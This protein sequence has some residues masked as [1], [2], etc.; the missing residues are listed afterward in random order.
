MAILMYG[1][2]PIPREVR[3]N[4]RMAGREDLVILLLTSIVFIM[5]WAVCVFKF[6]PTD[7]VVNFYNNAELIKD[8]LVPYRDFVF[9]F[10]PLSLP[11]FLIPSLFTSDLLV[12]SWLF[13][14]EV[15]IA[16]IATQFFLMRICEKVG[17]NRGAVALIFGLLVIMYFPES[18]KKFDMMVMM[19]TALAF[20]LYV[21]GRRTWA[22]AMFA[23]GAFIKMYPALFI[24]VL[25]IF[26]LSE[27]GLRGI[28]DILK[29]LL[30]V[31]V[32]VFV[33]I[34]PFLLMS[35]SLGEIFSF[36]EFHSERG[37]QVESFV[38]IVIQGMSLIGMTTFEL[39]GSHWTYD[40]VNPICDMLQP[41]WM[42]I[43]VILILLVFICTFL[44]IRK[45]VSYLDGASRFRLFVAS[46]GLI[47]IVFLLMNKVFSTQ[48]MIW[49][50][51]ITSILSVIPGNRLSVPMSVVGISAQFFSIFIVLNDSGTDPFIIA[52]ILRDISLILMA[53]ILLLYVFLDR[54]QLG[55]REVLDS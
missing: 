24:P 34:V 14:L 20:Y 52:N 50:F 51:P 45:K 19:S 11:F 41:Y 6:P 3:L 10:P 2:L 36:M 37:F 55:N 26:D 15:V 32:V 38:A 46:V 44:G 7:D 33:S 31:V 22:Y 39:V 21:S 1:T 35:L 13:G 29:G 43:S 5:A 53:A 23:V 4:G 54:G 30:S 40:V 42:S 27:K 8:G 28:P 25:M 48:Y 17:I 47:L 9:E 16:A 18:L 12:Y 49:L